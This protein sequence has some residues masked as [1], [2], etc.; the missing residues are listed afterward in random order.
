MSSFGKVS[1]ENASDGT[2]HVKSGGCWSCCLRRTLD[3]EIDDDTPRTIREPRNGPQSG[4]SAYASG[5][6]EEEDDQRDV[7][8]A[9][10]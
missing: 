2:V 7:F 10:M 1:R 9:G 6:T 4:Q 8:V 5:D 3:D